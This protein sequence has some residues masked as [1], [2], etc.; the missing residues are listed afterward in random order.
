MVDASHSDDQHRLDDGTGRDFGLDQFEA[1]T[2]DQGISLDQLSQAYAQLLGKGEDPY[3]P[4]GEPR[5]LEV[6]E[7][8][9]QADATPR[10]DTCEL[11]PRSIVEAILFVGHPR[12]EPMTAEQIAALMRGVPAREIDELVSELNQAYLRQGHAYHVASVDTGYRLELREEFWSMRNVFYGRV[13]EAR[14]SQAAVDVLAI[15]AYQQGLTRSEIDD[16]RGRP[17]GALLT[18]LVRRRLLRIDRPSKKPRTARY[19]T[20]DRFLELFGLSGLH[21]L[22]QS[23]DLD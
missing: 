2:D 12:N 13:R 8:V 23:Q 4:P 16:R 15:V 14:L 10:D 3:E 19:H 1:V 17:C 21:E 9:E 7:V 11:C 20:T 6:E 18:Q 5:E 22:P